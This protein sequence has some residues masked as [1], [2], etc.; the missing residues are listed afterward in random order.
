MEQPVGLQL[1]RVPVR[2]SDS[3]PCDCRGF[4]TIIYL[5]EHIREMESEGKEGQ[6]S[7]LAMR[8]L[9]C[10]ITAVIQFAL[11]TTPLVCSQMSWSDLR[12]DSKAK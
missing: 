1:D 12:L 8:S 6:R 11:L 5:L 9:I 7:G 3:A 2:C 4:C 10:K